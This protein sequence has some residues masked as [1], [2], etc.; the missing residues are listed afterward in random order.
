VSQEVQERAKPQVAAPS[1]RMVSIDALR[2]FDM[3]WLVG[4]QAFVA[5]VLGLCPKPVQQLLIPQLEHA[6]W[7]GFYFEDLIFPLFV[8]LVGMTTVFSLGKL[9]VQEGPAAAY[10]RLVRRAVALYLLGFIYYGGFSRLWPDIRLLGVLQR[11]A[12]CY[13]FTGMA[14]IHLRVRGIAAAFGAI[15]LVY[16]AWLS[17]VPVPGA[18]GVSFEPGKNWSN[19]LD[20]LLLPG[21]KWDKTWDPEGLLST[22][23]A[24]ATCLLGVLAAE[25][26]RT[27]RLSERLKVL[28]LIGGG[29]LGL[30]LG[31]AW[32]LQFPVIKK[33]WTSS[34][35]LV[36]GGYS[37]ILLGAFY[38]IVD[39]WKLRAW[40][41][42]FL[43]IGSNAIAL[44]MA[45]NIVSFKQLAD[46]LVGGD[47]KRALSALDPRA[48]TLLASAVALGLI[49][50]LAAFLYRRKIFLRV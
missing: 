23:P 16:W 19:Y 1:Q 49:L 14:V 13:F 15:L 37:C 34:Y 48:A 31:Y 8:F 45:V 9:L 32:G 43:W 36:A 35:V 4:G 11:I 17:F 24:I 46:R 18:G 25:L 44:Y 10:R 22:L 41:V 28:C 29:I 50:L 5:A 38:L 40:T 27:P 3:F 20:N 42:P 33:I 7:A 26:L 39:V 30:G 47:M 12:L 21:F 6:E 2:G